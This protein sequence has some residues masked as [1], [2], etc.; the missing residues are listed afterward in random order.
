M[1]SVCCCLRYCAAERAI[2]I[3][4]DDIPLPDPDQY[5]R[6]P[7]PNPKEQKEAQHVAVFIG[8]RAS[9]RYVEQMATGG[10]QRI[11][12]VVMPMRA[13]VVF[14]RMAGASGISDPVTG[15]EMSGKEVTE[16]R[17]DYYVGGLRH[18]LTQ[19]GKLG[20]GSTDRDKAIRKVEPAGGFSRVFVVP[21][22]GQSQ[23]IR[24]G[25]AFDFDVHHDQ[26]FPKQESF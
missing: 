22:G 15:G 4:D 6:K 20:S 9:T 24:G 26:L 16:R 1:M 8:Q 18:T 7:S 25:G 11:R 19:Y 3:T 21:L 10:G 5:I 13:S 17:A 14:G 2:S 12:R 23:G